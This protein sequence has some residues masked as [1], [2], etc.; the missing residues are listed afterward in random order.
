MD[1]AQKNIPTKEKAKSKRT[2]I[3]KTHVFQ[4]RSKGLKKPA[5]QAQV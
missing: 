3:Y 4:S 2:R 5:A 1:Y